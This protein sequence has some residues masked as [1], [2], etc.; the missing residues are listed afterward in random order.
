MLFLC[1]VLLP[2]C[3][4][5]RPPELTTRGADLIRS[6][7]GEGGAYAGAELLAVRTDGLLILRQGAVYF[8]PAEVASELRFTEEGRQELGD[9]SDPGTLD[10]LR[11]QARYP[12]GLDEGQ[13]A[14]LLRALDQDSLLTV[15][16]G[17]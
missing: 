8:V 5:R 7:R 17:G 13:L 1:A 4:W 10:R 6:P 11:Y 15:R 16:P 3:H 14:A 12:G 2:G 9:P